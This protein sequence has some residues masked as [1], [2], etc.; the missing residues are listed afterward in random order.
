M[1]QARTGRLVV[2]A[3]EVPV[4]EL[5][6]LLAPETLLQRHLLRETTEEPG[7]V[8][9]VAP[10]EAA[11]GAGQEARAPQLR[12]LRLLAAPVVP[13]SLHPYRV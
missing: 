8:T 13:E 4:A 9:Q 2:P 5:L 11:A 12:G 7:V 10:M 3:V 6:E 1:G